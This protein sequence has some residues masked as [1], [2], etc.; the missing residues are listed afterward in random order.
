MAKTTFEYGDTVENFE[1][2]EGQYIF[3]GIS[4]NSKSY[5]G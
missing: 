2:L 1:K 5:I 4:Y 3:Q